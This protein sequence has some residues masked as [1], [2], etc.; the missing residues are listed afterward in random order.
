[1]FEYLK[2]KNYKGITS[3]LELRELGHI[4]VL[5]GKNNSGKTSIL[6][7]IGKHWQDSEK[8]ALGKKINKDELVGP[9]NRQAVQKNTNVHE[10]QEW[11]AKYCDE[12]IK[13]EAI[14]YTDTIDDHINDM[15]DYQ[16]NFIYRHSGAMFDFNFNHILVNFFA[17]LEGKYNPML[18]PPKRSINYSPA[19]TVLKDRY[20]KNNGEYVANLLFDLKS[21]DPG[22]SEVETYNKI[23][24]A[25]ETITGC[26]FSISMSQVREHEL[27]LSFNIPN[28]IKQWV[29]GDAAGLGLSDVLVLVTFIIASDSTLILIEEPENHLHPEMQRK[30]L[31]FIKT[32]KDK[33]FIISTHSNVFLDPYVVDKIFF[34]EYEGGVKVTDKTS[35]SEMLYNIG[36]SVADNLVSDMLLLVEGPTDIPVFHAIFDWMGLEEKYN[37]RLWPLGGDIMSYLDLSVFTERNNVFAVIDSDPPSHK[38]RKKFQEKCE[39]YKIPCRTLE[40]YAIENYF[41]LDAIKKVLP[42]IPEDILKL[43]PD[44]KVEKQL[45]IN[46]KN[47]NTKIIKNM[48]LDDVVGTDLYDICID[49]RTY[50]KE[51]S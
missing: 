14:L 11:F 6:E 19:V 45:G 38:I 47:N 21:K 29:S 51:N 13:K 50:L 20:Y 18:I 2:V 39:E 44:Q 49:F 32:I 26:S 17:D 1:M 35:K 33:Q 9:F 10:N 41:T 25:F 22:A 40:R 48:S 4:N 36:Y 8:F 3:D 30:F 43:E 37:I 28:N 34:V 23:D 12:S 15:S 24:N 31:H 5:C 42:D 46:I 16:K 7:V 27:L